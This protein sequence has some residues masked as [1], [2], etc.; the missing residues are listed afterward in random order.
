[1]RVFREPSPPFPPL[2]DSPLSHHDLCIR[3]TNLPAA[4]GGHVLSEMQLMHKALVNFVL[5][6][7]ALPRDSVEINRHNILMFTMTTPSE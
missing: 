2:A 7:L 4:L 6:C 1:M 5:V 3:D